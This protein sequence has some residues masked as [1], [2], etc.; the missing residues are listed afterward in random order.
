MR[1]SALMRAR[2]WRSRFG[3]GTLPD[4]KRYA[5]SVNW[6]GYHGTN[7]FAANALLRVNDNIVI[8]GGIGVGVTKGDVGGRAGVTYA[9]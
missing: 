3:G 7:A 4:N 6:G 2:Q 1:C 9:W 5:V 8:N